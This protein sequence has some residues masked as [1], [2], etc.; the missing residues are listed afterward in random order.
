MEHEVTKPVIS[1]DTLIGVAAEPWTKDPSA[2]PEY[3]TG[4]LYEPDEIIL[5]AQVDMISAVIGEDATKVRGRIV[6]EAKNRAA[7]R[8]LRALLD[9]RQASVVRLEDGNWADALEGDDRG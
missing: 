6:R 1:I 9:S 8:N 7:E 2:I 4:R 3:L 5:R